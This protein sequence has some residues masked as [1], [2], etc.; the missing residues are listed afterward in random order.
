MLV[1]NVESFIAQAQ[2]FWLDSWPEHLPGL[3]Y[4]TFQLGWVVG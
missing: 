2:V 4:K 1:G 3:S